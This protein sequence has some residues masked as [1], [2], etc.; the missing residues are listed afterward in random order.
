MG[1]R[2]SVLGHVVLNV[3]DLK[4][5]EEFYR[6]ILGMPLLFKADPA[7]A[8]FDIHGIRLMLSQSNEVP[9]GGPILYFSVDE[10]DPAYQEIA[11]KGANC[12]RKR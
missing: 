9:A 12:L 7:M 6:D 2:Q 11:D 10:I 5:S 1:I 8:F 4:V 3:R